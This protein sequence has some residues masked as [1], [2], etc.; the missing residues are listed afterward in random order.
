MPMDS[1]AL[2]Q[3]NR[4]F[5]QLLDCICSSILAGW[6][7]QR[8][9]LCIIQKTNFFFFFLLVVLVLLLYFSFLISICSYLCI[10]HL[11]YVANVSEWRWNK[12]LQAFVSLTEHDFPD[13]E[14][15]SEG[16]WEFIFVSAS[17]HSNIHLWHTPILSVCVREHCSLL[18]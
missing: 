17:L 18:S 11:V 15:C 10:K 13:Q 9:S 14:F 1:E 4:F 8:A 6:G 16:R 3:L 2:S 5:P 12:C 7:I